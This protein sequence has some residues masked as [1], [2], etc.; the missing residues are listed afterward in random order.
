[1]GGGGEYHIHSNT[2]GYRFRSS[3]N[4]HQEHPIDA[5]AKQILDG[6]DV[7][8]DGTV[9]KDEVRNCEESK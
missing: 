4:S 6:M 2:E 1:M 9:T 3:S 5:R 7:D 8:H